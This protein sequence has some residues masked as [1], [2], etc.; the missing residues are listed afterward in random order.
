M[1]MEVNPTWVCCKVDVENAHSAMSRAAVV[2]TLEEQPEL[3]HMAW[4]FA[5][6]MAATTTLE[7][8]GQSWGEAGDGLVQ[9]KPTSMAY[10]C[11]GLQPELSQVDRELREEGGGLARVAA[12]DCYIM[13]PPDVAFLT[14][15]RFKER[16]RYRL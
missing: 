5:T 11:V 16:I 6:S 10:F 15:D 7:T 12:D 4:Y 13:G 9:G 8:G 3:R 1:V 2:E 14:L